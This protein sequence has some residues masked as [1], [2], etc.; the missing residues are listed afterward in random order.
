MRIDSTGRLHVR[1]RR[2]KVLRTATNDAIARA[3]GYK[4]TVSIAVVW[5]LERLV[6][7]HRI[8]LDGR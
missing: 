3:L 4:D 6:V 2:R 1:Q 5:I 8:G 7:R